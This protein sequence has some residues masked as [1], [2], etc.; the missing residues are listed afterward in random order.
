MG[1]IDAT[2][3]YDDT[4]KK[5]F[6]IWKSDGNAVNKPTDILMKELTVDGLSFQ[7]PADKP[8]FL[9]TDTD[10]WE[11]GITEGP[12]MLKHNN[13]YYV[14]YSGNGYANPQYSIGV[15]RSQS[16]YGEYEKYV[17]NPVLHVDYNRFF[18]GQNCTFVGPGHN[19]IV[20]G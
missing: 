17:K 3:F 13:Y 15:A 9:F 1:S 18:K 14:F 4:T 11:N 8:Y 6:L 5:N 16:I 20:S 19:S 12:W 10:F 2:Q 7:N